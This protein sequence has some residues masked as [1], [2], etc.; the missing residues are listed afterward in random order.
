MV[1]IRSSGHDF[2][3]SSSPI[4][5]QEMSETKEKGDTGED[6]AV[7]GSDSARKTDNSEQEY[8][9]HSVESGQVHETID[10]GETVP[11]K[12]DIE[13]T[14]A[15]EDNVVESGKGQETPKPTDNGETLRENTDIEM[16]AADDANVGP[17]STSGQSNQEPPPPLVPEKGDD[18]ELVK[19]GGDTLNDDDQELDKP[20]DEPPS[21]VKAD[22]RELPLNSDNGYEENAEPNSGAAG[23][24]ITASNNEP[25]TPHAGFS[26]IKDENKNGKELENKVNGKEVT[27][28]MNNGKSSSK[29]MFLSDDSHTYD[30]NDSGTEEEQL[31]FMKEIENFFKER[32]M[33]FK[34][35]KFY[36]D[37][38]NCLKLYR[39]V[40][41]LG[42]YDKVTSS[43]LWRQV[44]ASFKPPRT[45][46]TIS[47]SFRG[48]YEKALLD[49]EKHEMH[50][51]ELSIPIPSQPKPI[52][53]D[54]RASGSGRT[55]RD[56]A[57]RAMQGWHSQRLLG[58]GE[59]S[60]PIIK[61]KNANA[62]QKQ[63]K[64]L[65]TSGSHKRKKPPN[66]DPVVQA[67]RTKP[68]KL[69]LD[70]DVSD[71]GPPA[72]WVK[73]NVQK[74]KDC[75]EVYALVPGLLREEVRVQTDPAGRLVISGEPEHPDNP[76]GVT[77]FK[78]AVSLPSRI[79]PHHTS[80]VVTLHGQ[81]FVRVPFEQLE[82]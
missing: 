59:V 6:I 8:S 14:A 51:G 15:D 46:T 26:D 31:D 56:A 75:F 73:V 60:E 67:A 58:N 77:P 71:L 1:R 19:Q 55:R 70:V 43:K 61:D 82:Q 11:E 34:P 68:T 9:F 25:A 4:P 24:I 10:N 40:T 52:N 81:L 23:D 47:W 78:K 36:G 44:G 37:C 41:R 79:D 28:P 17:Q 49:Y 80:A 16:T 69:Q 45:C 66:V 2:K 5:N 38:V 72:D 3:P 48:F 74:T 30:G 35:P 33:E 21:D 42:G 39:I 64:Q 57:A 7:D 22:M 65:K 12:T 20:G 27:T 50:G 13:M 63:E 29:Y 32:S 62:L 76:W 54:N 18:G 53:I